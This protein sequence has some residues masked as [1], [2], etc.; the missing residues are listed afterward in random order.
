M[1]WT[2]HKPANCFLGRQHKEGEKMKP[3]KANSIAFAA[4][5][6]LAVNPQFASLMALVAN[7]EE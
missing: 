5:A 2:I 3:L 6:A 1:A 4:A 7:L